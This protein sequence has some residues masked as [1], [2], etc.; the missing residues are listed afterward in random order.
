MVENTQ[1][2][3]KA[4]EWYKHYMTINPNYLLAE[5]ASCK[6]RDNR[7]VSPALDAAFD[8]RRDEMDDY[9]IT[10]EERE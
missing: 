6:V 1:S 7:E 2:R 4:I 10:I 8:E 3:R 5:Y 9:M